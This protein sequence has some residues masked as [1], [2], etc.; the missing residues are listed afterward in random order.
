MAHHRG[1]TERT[2]ASWAD[3][4]HCGAAAACHR[5]GRSMA[6]CRPST[7]SKVGAAGDTL[8]A[9]GGDFSDYQQLLKSLLGQGFIRARIDGVVYELDTPPALD[10]KRKHSIDVVVDRVV[11]KSDLAQRLAESFETALAVADSLAL[12]QVVPGDDE[13][14][15]QEMLF[16]ARYACPHCGYNLTELEPRLFSFNNP[17]DMAFW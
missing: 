5:P 13:A 10:R 2:Y 4:C 14:E 7:V 11:I 6:C 9:A 12:V 15:A 16:S 1:K 17:A 8:L 3:Q